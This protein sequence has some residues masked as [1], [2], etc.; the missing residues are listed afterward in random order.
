[1]NHAGGILGGLVVAALTWTSLS[2]WSKSSVG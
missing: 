1:M 2:R